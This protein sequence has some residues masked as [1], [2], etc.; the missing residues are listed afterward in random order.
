MKT[1]KAMKPSQ[2]G[3][4]F[5]KQARSGKAGVTESTQFPI[6]KVQNADPALYPERGKMCQCCCNYLVSKSWNTFV[7]LVLSCWLA[8]F[9]PSS[10]RVWAKTIW[11]RQARGEDAT[12]PPFSP[13]LTTC[14]WMLLSLTVRVVVEFKWT[15]HLELSC[16]PISSAARIAQARQISKKHMFFFQLFRMFF[17]VQCSLF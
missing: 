13:N 10:F 11:R 17:P 1:I 4:L 6:A 3:E 8:A 15:I 5:Q 14:L 9:V 2:I 7:Y 12:R 16:K